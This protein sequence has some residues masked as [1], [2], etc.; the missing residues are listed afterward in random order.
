[1]KPSEA[2]ESHGVSGE[3]FGGYN[4]RFLTQNMRSVKLS[5][6]AR[7]LARCW[8][9]LA[10]KIP[11]RHQRPDLFLAELA[12]LQ[13]RFA[14]EVVFDA[15]S[16]NTSRQGATVAEAHCELNFIEHSVLL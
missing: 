10:Q 8:N 12:D 2:V 7:R 16:D 15:R 1:V 4:P 11:A 9:I 3:D 14:E 5:K 13:S 6:R